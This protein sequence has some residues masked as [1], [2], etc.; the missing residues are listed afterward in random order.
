MKQILIRRPVPEEHGPSVRLSAELE[1]DARRTLFFE[2]AGERRCDLADDRADA[3]VVMLLRHALE[4]GADIRSEAPV[5]TELLY[6]LNDFL[7]PTLARAVSRFHPMKVMADGCGPSGGT[8]TAAGY[9]GGVDSLYTLARHTGPEENR[10]G[11]RLDAL[12][13]FDAGV[14]EESGEARDRT[15]AEALRE[16]AE[17]AARFGLG[18]IGVRSNIQNLVN[19]HYLGVASFRLIACAMAAGRRIGTFLLS[20]A[21]EFPAFGVDADNSA[22]YDLLIAEQLSTSGFRIYIPGGPLKR[23]E[24]IGYLA[25]QEEA[26]RNL[27][28]VCVRDPLPLGRNCG[29]CPKCIRTELAMEG[30]GVPERFGAV[31]PWDVI[32]AHHDEIVAK[33][34]LSSR[35]PHAAEALRALEQ[36]GYRDT[37]E[38]RRRIRGGAAAAAVVS[39]RREELLKRMEEGKRRERNPE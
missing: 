33:A 5:S 7:I 16:T 6:H 35:N 30:L 36:R 17:T 20:G 25:E 19:E 8:E 32:R 24:K 38:I 10:P 18:C 22:C 26:V 29:L 28:H 11:L 13:C 4:T 14:Y 39:R 34:R 15:Y 9:S 31:F 3:F 2:T 37:E 23:I 1:T 12:A 21:Y 27:L